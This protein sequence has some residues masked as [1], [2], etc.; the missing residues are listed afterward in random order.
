LDNDTNLY[1]LA[2][3]NGKGIIYR[4]ID[5]RN[6]DV[7]FDFRSITYYCYVSKKTGNTQKA[8]FSLFTKYD[9]IG[10]DSTI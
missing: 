10:D 3:A 9:Y 8:E 5:E 7:N 6:N 1:P 2:N 4:L